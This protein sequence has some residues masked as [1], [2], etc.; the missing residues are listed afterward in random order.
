MASNLEEGLGGAREKITDFYSEWREFALRKNAFDVATGLMIGTALT[1]IAKSL[2]NDI[3]TPLI[4]ASWAGA[5]L[6][7]LFVVLVAGKSGSKDY[8]TPAQAEDDGAVT[9]NY[10]RFFETCIDFVFVSLCIFVLYKGLLSVKKTVE[11]RATDVT[12]LASNKKQGDA[13]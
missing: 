2:V 4:I 3:L 9:F 12:A 6:S 7:N 1:A 13:V 11:A 5:S 8:E 10:G